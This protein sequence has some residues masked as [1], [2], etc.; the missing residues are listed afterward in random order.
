[1]TVTKG[2]APVVVTLNGRPVP[3]AGSMIEDPTVTTRYRLAATIGGSGKQMGST[4]ALGGE[5][6]GWRFADRVPVPVRNSNGP[7]PIEARRVAA[8]LLGALSKTARASFLDKAIEVHIIPVRRRPTG[9]SALSC[10]SE[11]PSRRDL[12]QRCR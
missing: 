7:A 3:A 10:I 1:L 2:C 12:L 4:I 11:R 6:I 9:G 8:R 5:V